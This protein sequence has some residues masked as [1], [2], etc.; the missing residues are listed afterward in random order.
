MS[1]PIGDK[2]EYLQE[3]AEQPS[4]K[5]VKREKAKPDEAK[6]ASRKTATQADA[7]KRARRSTTARKRKA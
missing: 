3:V 6:R 7:P 1:N 4:E 2:G 5:A